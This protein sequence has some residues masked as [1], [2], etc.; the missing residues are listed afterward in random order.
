VLAISSLGLIYIIF[1]QPVLPNSIKYLD[2]SVQNSHRSVSML[3]EVYI[4]TVPLPLAADDT[5]AY[6]LG[7]T[8]KI[9]NTDEWRANWCRMYR[10]EGDWVGYSYHASHMYVIATLVE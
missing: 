5:R 2:V 1:R 3:A 7:H 10:L 6:G 4:L 9:A 8:T